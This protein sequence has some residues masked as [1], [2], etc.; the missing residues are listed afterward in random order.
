MNQKQVK[1]LFKKSEKKNIGREELPLSI[2]KKL[3]N[4]NY[5]LVQ[6]PLREN[7]DLLLLQ[8][9]ISEEPLILLLIEKDPHQIEIIKEF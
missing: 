1:E 4:D 5:I 7:A 9:L 6:E 3:S 2:Q 8:D